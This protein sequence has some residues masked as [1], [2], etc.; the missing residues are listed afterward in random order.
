M[1]STLCT[2]VRYEGVELEL[3]N[4][5]HVYTK[6]WGRASSRFHLDHQK[7]VDSG[8]LKK[9]S[10]LN[11]FS[12]AKHFVQASLVW[13]DWARAFK[14]YTHINQGLKSCLVKV[15]SRSVENCRFW[16]TLKIVDF[17]HFFL[18]MPS[19]LCRRVWYEAIEG[20]RATLC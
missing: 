2:R 11:F 20:L 8:A 13:S 12:D 18:Q 7:I 14:V 17:N 4:F 9:L 5:I 3:W 6:V 10:I 19:T 15:L 1:L 16:S